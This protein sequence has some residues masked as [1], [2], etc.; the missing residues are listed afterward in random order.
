MKYFYFWLF[1]FVLYKQDGHYLL[2]L[3]YFHKDRNFSNVLG[4]EYT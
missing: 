3:F 1:Y 2:N 4:D